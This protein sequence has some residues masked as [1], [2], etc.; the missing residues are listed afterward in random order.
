MHI[1]S[2]H[3]EKKKNSRVIYVPCRNSY[4]F[5]STCEYSH[6]MSFRSFDFGFS[7]SERK[8]SLVY[9]N[10]T[11]YYDQLTLKMFSE[12]RD[13]W[14]V[15]VLTKKFESLYFNSFYYFAPAKLSNLSVFWTKTSRAIMLIYSS[16]EIIDWMFFETN[17]IWASFFHVI[18]SKNDTW[19]G[20]VVKNQKKCELSCHFGHTNAKTCLLLENNIIGPTTFHFKRRSGANL[21]GS[22]V[23]RIRAM[24]EIYWVTI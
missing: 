9:V 13:S 12:L 4:V 23:S 15:Y 7:L 1:I 14:E 22:N 16:K 17:Y 2:I 24:N 11:R 18:F 10:Y 19:N 21:D 8:I 5:M 6:S 20:K 3:L